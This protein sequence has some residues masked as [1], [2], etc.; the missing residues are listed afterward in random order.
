MCSGKE[1]LGRVAFG[2][3]AGWEVPVEGGSLHPWGVLFGVGIEAE[4]W[5]NCDRIQMSLPK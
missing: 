1:V 4:R 2:E 5:Y 3:V